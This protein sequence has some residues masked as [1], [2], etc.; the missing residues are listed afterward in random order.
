VVKP[1]DE[2]RRVAMFKDNKLRLLLTLVG[3]DRLG[4]HD[5]PDATWTIPS[6][7]T[8]A[9]LQEAIDLIR[10]Y[11]FD[12]PTYEDGKGPEA[13]LRSKAATSKRAARKV[14]FDDDSDGID[15]DVDEDHGEYAADG[16]T[17]RKADGANKKGLK[18]GRRART[19]VDLSDDEK[20]R[21]AEARR[22]REI[23]KQKAEKSTMFVHDSDD[24][25][26]D[27]ERDAAFFAQEEA[28]R[29]HTVQAFIRSG[30]LGST[31]M[32]TARKRKADEPAS[33]KSKRRKSPPRRK[34]GPFDE[35][36]AS[37]DDNAVG[38]AESAT[39]S[40]AQSVEALVVED[41]ES[42]NE[43]T[44][45]PL[46]SQHAP[47]SKE[48]ASGPSEDADVV[49]RNADDDDEDEDDVPVARRSTARRMR[50]GFVID[51]DSE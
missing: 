10:K 42:E 1:D 50:A 37:E 25:D 49:M 3:F 11:E 19:P 38:S 31:E 20:E 4:A 8:S 28:I 6:S 15:N 5:D 16:P 29:A 44:D 23:E 12:P 9:D 32:A 34:K 13:M 18:R 7:L 36:D 24:E 48:S 43:A 27:E 41:D 39:S 21:R 22:K 26:W 47:P 33:E 2:E 45:T 17:A 46:S 30:A 14:D 35:S 40:R 51:S